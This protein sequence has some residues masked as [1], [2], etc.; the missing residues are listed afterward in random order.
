MSETVARL[1]ALRHDAGMDE[2][3]ISIVIP[4]RDE[5]RAA[6]A[7][8]AV[9]AQ[10]GIQA[11]AE[12]LVVG[13]GVP[14]LPED[15]RVIRVETNPASSPGANRNRGIERARGTILIFLDADCVP[16]PGWLRALGKRLESAPVVSGAVALDADGYWA[17]AYNVTTFSLFRESLPAGARPFLATLTLGVRREVIDAVGPLDESLFRCEDMDWTMRMAASGIPLAFEP[18]AVVEHRPASSARLALLKWWQS[19]AA[20]LFVR[21]RHAGANAG[22]D[23]LALFPPWALRL[24]SPVLALGATLRVFR[25]PG[26]WRYLHT[27]PVVYVTKVAWCLGAARPADRIPR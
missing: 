20:S 15:P 2:P 6:R 21:R 17:T 13:S 4:V 10:D 27:L 23:A 22:R 11:V 24:L 14:P 26:S 1:A 25:S 3:T 12:I 8:A 9:L 7:V 19:G 16:R 5:P 18:G